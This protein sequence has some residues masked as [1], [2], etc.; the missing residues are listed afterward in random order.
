MAYWRLRNSRAYRG[1]AAGRVEADAGTLILER[2]PGGRVDHRLP[3]VVLAVPTRGQR[4]RI[5]DVVQGR[6]ESAGR[7]AG[8]HHGRRR[9]CRL[10]RVPLDSPPDVREGQ[11]RSSG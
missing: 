6:A 5:G 4:L 3:A 2:D 7:R 11:I 10:E 9:T 8:E 1:L